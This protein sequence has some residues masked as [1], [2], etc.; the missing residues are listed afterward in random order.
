MQ[1]KLLISIIVSIL[2]L[3]LWQSQLQIRALKNNQAQPENIESE[4]VDYNKVSGE[5]AWKQAEEKI[6][7][8]EKIRRA[9]EDQYVDPPSATNQ[10]DFQARFEQKCQDEQ[11]KYNSCL[12]KY[13]TEMLEYQNCQSGNKTFGCS[14]SSWQPI[15]TCGANVSSSCRKQ[16]LGHY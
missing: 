12:I 4:H 11:A 14:L 2:G 10:P 8:Q 1:K 15:N 13:N 9:Q 7:Q 5:S 16:V 6:R 3:L